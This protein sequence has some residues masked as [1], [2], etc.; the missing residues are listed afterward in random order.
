M[1]EADKRTSRRDVI[2]GIGAAAGAAALA[3]A[4]GGSKEVEAHEINAMVPTAEQIQEYIA[5]DYEGP[6]VM[7]NLLKFKPDGGREA[8]A[9][10]GMSVMPILKKIG[11]KILFTSETLYCLLGHGDWDSIALVEYPSK[12]AM[13]QMSMMPEYQ[14]IHHHREEGL[15]GQ[16]NYAVIQRQM[17][18]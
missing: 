3:A 2:K 1:K 12:M 5:L 18:G 4:V 13:I 8:Y 16:I 17:P 14:A 7:V 15:E 10:Y 6:I 9:R 11:A